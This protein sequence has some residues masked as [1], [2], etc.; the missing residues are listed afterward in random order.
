MS[1]KLMIDRRFWPAFWT[2]FWGA[3]NDNV[4]KNA[5]V[6][7]IT[8]RSYTLAGLGGDQLVALCGGIFILP[9]FLFSALAGQITDKFSKSK[10]IFWIKVW[11]IAVMLLGAVGFF[12]E[13]LPIL[14]TTLFMM[15]LQ[16]TF[17]GPVKYSILPELVEDEELVQGN[18]L[19][20]MG[21]FVSILMGTILGGTLIGLESY[22]TRYVAI[23]T[24][25]IAVIG[26]L[27][28]RKVNYVEPT[29]PSLKINWGI[30]KPTWDILKLAK[31]KK[32]VWNSILAISWFWFVGAGLLSIF[33]VYVRD[34]IGGNE[35]VVTLFLALF[36]IGVA[37]GSLLCEYL[38]R[39]RLELGLVPIGS[40]GI[41]VFIIDLYFAT[42]AP[43][44]DS[45]IGASEF[46]K[47]IPNWRIIFDLS[48]LSLSS[49][50]FIVPLYT[51]IQH[52]S[53]AQSRSR[54]IASNNIVNAIFMVIA[55]VFLAIL[56]SLGVDS[57][58]IFLIIGVLNI[59]VALY[60]YTVIPEFLLRF[61]FMMVARLIYRL[62]V[63]GHDSIPHEG[64]AVLVCNHVSF[65][66]WM[67]IAAGIKRPVRFVMHHSFMKNPILRF[68]L[69]GAKVIP[70]A[71]KNDN[72]Q[73]LQ[74][75]FDKIKQELDD[76]EVI[77]IFPEGKI[78]AD[79]KLNP[80]RPGIEAIIKDNP[81]PVIPMTIHG[82]W[83]SF[84]SRK[85]GA[86]ASKPLI[87]L[88][89]IWSKLL[90]EIEAPIAANE[91][92]ASDL[93]YRARRKML[94]HAKEYDTPESE[95]DSVKV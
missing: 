46:I 13:N 78:T 64:A 43:L 68:F 45:L 30:F 2:Q 66:D 44:G 49:G 7:M 34:V 25:L 4:F 75:A 65:V 74:A 3:F 90:L 50:L 24:I 69:R 41:S 86:A 60:I 27:F 59:I 31:E 12:F 39:E 93:E 22:G 57:M 33:P 15:G 51:Y 8:Y 14:L 32:G 40:I 77:C 26:T 88:K 89:T 63:K 87:I 35:Q 91:V 20:E 52:Y 83:G 81:V 71:G 42:P 5:L 18:A 76:G 58:E 16:S 73:I 80:Y 70:I 19:I 37:I 28:S 95:L 11:E 55:S 36:S 54:V 21:T 82:L 6:I 61:S 62:K 17:F 94:E 47:Q 84:F 38:S 85:Y 9:F 79:G 67:I 1:S 29:E 56:Y 72:S 48:F 92:S 23:V 53:D 10:L